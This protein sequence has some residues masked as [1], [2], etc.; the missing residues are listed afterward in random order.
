MLEAQYARLKSGRADNPKMEAFGPM[1]LD[2]M[3][4]AAEH[5]ARVG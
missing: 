2:L 4:R 5:A 3:A 1:T